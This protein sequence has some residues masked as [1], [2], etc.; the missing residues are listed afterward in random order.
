MRGKFTFFASTNDHAANIAFG[1]ACGR[2]VETPQV[3]PMIGLTKK[4]EKI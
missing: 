4:T 3:T 2:Q 1:K